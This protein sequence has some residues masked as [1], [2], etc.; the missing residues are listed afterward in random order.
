VQVTAGTCFAPGTTFMG[1]DIRAV[2]GGRDEEARQCPGPFATRGVI[3]RRE[4]LWRTETRS[5]Q[6]LGNSPAGSYPQ[7]DQR[8]DGNRQQRGNKT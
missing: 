3:A 7:R 8:Q 4:A 6:Q 2:A 5:K 1:I